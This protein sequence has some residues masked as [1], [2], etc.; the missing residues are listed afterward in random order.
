MNTLSRKQREIAERE[1]KILDVSRKMLAKDGYLGLSMDR[2]AA[3]MEYSKGTI[4]QHF[5]CKEDVI[6]AMVNQAM[7]IRVDM[8]QRA[9]QFRGTSRERLAAIGTAAELFA[10]LHPDY[11]NIE[12][13]V[14]LDSIWEK[15]S[16]ERREMMRGCEFRCVSTM[17]GVVRDA[18]AAGDLELPDETTPEDLVFGLWSINFGAFSILSTST[19]LAEI[20]IKDP[21]RAL[22]TD[23]NMMLDGCGWRPL[24]SEH[25]YHATIERIQ[26]EVFHEES[27]QT[28][29]A[30]A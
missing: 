29:A 2:I 11:F 23:I 12:Q 28:A 6:I 30:V 18:I 21:L 17:T 20:G 10:Q 8:F 22:R 14:R 9:A 26:R 13:I 16:A 19:S 15:I 25:D 4:Y 27:K 3:E 7:D 24:S 1:E 5:G